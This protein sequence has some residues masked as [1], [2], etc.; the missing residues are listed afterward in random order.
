MKRLTI[1][2]HAKS[3]WPDGVDDFERPLNDRGRTAAARVGEELKARHLGFDL[4]LAS[5]ATRVRETLD[6]I[7]Q[8]Y[9]ALPIQFDEGLYL[10]SEQQL[11]RRA[12]G[13]PRNVSSLMLVGHN[14]GLERLVADLAV[15][16]DRGLRNRVM[17]GLPTAA[18]AVLN[19]MIDDW[20]NATRGG[21]DFVDLI[22]PREPD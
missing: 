22:L 6:G 13:V 3:G 17:A 2:R 5:P 10:A 14:P 8:S 9:G 1:L 15:D 12:R 20:A 7:T 21:A 16:D 11:L 4:V 19:L 18:A